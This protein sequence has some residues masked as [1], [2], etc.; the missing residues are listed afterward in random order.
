[1]AIAVQSSYTLVGICSVRYS[2][3]IYFQQGRE[4]IYT[5]ISI[6]T[7]IGVIPLLLL[8]GWG[9]N[10]TTDSNNLDLKLMIV[11]LIFYLVG[12]AIFV[13]GYHLRWYILQDI[14]QVI[15]GFNMM[16]LIGL[17]ALG[18][19]LKSHTANA[20]VVFSLYGM[21]GFIA[22]VVSD[23]V[24]GNLFKIRPD[25]PYLAVCLPWNILIFIL[26]VIGMAC[27]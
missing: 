15:N 19:G 7:A 18:R 1:M 6:I 12:L 2:S 3:N 11:Q 8:L 24:C 25:L 20:G 21:S 14:G 16:G 9:L 22:T 17:A 23:A 5:I 13:T 26:I 10:K 4:D 27:C